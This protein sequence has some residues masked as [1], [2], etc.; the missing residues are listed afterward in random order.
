MGGVLSRIASTSKAATPVLTASVMATRSRRGP[1]L[2]AALR[3]YSGYPRSAVPGDQ[4]SS[5]GGFQAR[6][7][8]SMRLIWIF[9][10]HL[11]RCWWLR[12]SAQLARARTGVP[13][14]VGQSGWRCQARAD[15]VRPWAKSICKVLPAGIRE[16]RTRS[17]DRRRPS[18]RRISS[19][20]ESWFSLSF[21]AFPQAIRRATLP[22]GAN[23]AGCH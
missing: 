13:A 7:T 14:Q 1:I 21:T 23:R 2:L 8:F 11:L 19:R 12:A 6:R 9:M 3:E 20:P 4:L 22:V 15:V 10:G 5:S 18:A 16:G 17:A